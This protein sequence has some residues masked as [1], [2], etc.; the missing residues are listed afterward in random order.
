M[1]VR[2]PSRPSE[3]EKPRVASKGSSSTS[4][5]PRVRRQ[6]A[7]VSRTARSVACAARRPR[8]GGLARAAV[9]RTR[10][11]AG[12]VSGS[13]RPAP[14]PT[15]RSRPSV[16]RAGLVEAQGVDAAQRLQRARRA[17]EHAEAGQP[18]RRRELREPSR[19]A[20][21]PRGRRPP[22]RAT[23]VA[24]RARAAA[25]AQHPQRRD[26][27]AAEHGRG[28]RLA[29]ELGQPVLDAGRGV[30]RPAQRCC[31]AWVGAGSRLHV[32]VDGHRFTGEGRLVHL[33]GLRPQQPGICGND[34]L[35]AKQDQVA[36]PQ[37]ARRDRFRPGRPQLRER[38]LV[39][40]ARR[41]QAAGP[42]PLPEQQ[43]PERPFR[44]HPLRRR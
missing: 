28:D 12:P 8:G 20:A 7:R 41:R 31:A 6:A 15:S 5:Q 40:G 26:G 9:R 24:E 23:P 38:L 13:A 14:T 34:V 39:R 18:P 43:V 30:H 27:G 16:R 44:P 33:Q 10:R 25:A 3:A 36:G 11:P 37:L 35:G 4:V 17:D 22:R 19:P 21:A 32:L 2:S 29:G 42:D 1:T